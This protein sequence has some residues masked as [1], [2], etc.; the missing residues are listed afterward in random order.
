MFVC[1]ENL[2]QFFNAVRTYSCIEFRYK[3]GG[4]IASKI[5]GYSGLLY[6]EEEITRGFEKFMFSIVIKTSN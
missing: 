4:E 5:Q 2:I 3:L 6:F 1:V